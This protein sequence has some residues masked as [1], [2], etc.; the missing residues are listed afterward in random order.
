MPDE[1][2]HEELNDNSKLWRVTQKD[3][4]TALSGLDR[5]TLAW[6]DKIATAIV[7]HA[8][9]ESVYLCKMDIRQRNARDR[10]PYRDDKYEVRAFQGKWAAFRIADNVRM[11][12][13]H[14]RWESARSE[15]WNLTGVMV[16]GWAA[17]M[18][19]GRASSI[20]RGDLLSPLRHPR[21]I[22]R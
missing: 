7:D 2:S 5:V 3:K 12:N 9:A 14:D 13:L 8:D 11:G 16:A 22:K 1:I 21:T 10:T 19:I 15:I 17:N 20:R 4:R 18:T 6:H